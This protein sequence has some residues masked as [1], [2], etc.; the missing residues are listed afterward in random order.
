MP[1]F[2][3]PG[4]LA[5]VGEQIWAVDEFQPVAAVLD[6]QAGRIEQLVSYAAELPAPP[7][8]EEDPWYAGWRVLDTSAGIWVQPFSGGPIAL[9]TTGGLAHAGHSAGTRLQAATEAG[10]WAAPHPPEQDIA[11]LPATPPKLPL[12]PTELCHIRPDGTIMRPRVDRP[13]RELRAGPGGAYVRVDIEPWSRHDLGGSGHWDLAYEQKW[14]LLAPPTAD[15]ETY[16]V[17]EQPAA[18]PPG[19]PAWLG[20]GFLGVG[21]PWHEP[22]DSLNP[23][24]PAGGLRWVLGWDQQQFEHSGE[25]EILATGHHPVSNTEHRRVMLGAGEVLAAAPAKPYLWAAIRRGRPFSPQREQPVELTRID[26]RT[27][28]I[29]TPVPADS[30]EITD[31]RWPRPPKPVEADSYAEYQRRQFDN[32]DT[33]W[34]PVDGGPPKPLATGMRD[35]RSE[36]AGTWPETVVRISFTHEHFPGLRLVRTLPIFDELGRQDPPEYADINLMEDLDTGELPPTSDAADGI[37]QI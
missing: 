15:D 3:R 9:I 20:G 18:S 29:E 23:G 28:H 22:P 25:R 27:N 26:T 19:L 32:L 36:L 8:T 5:P 30:V 11:E 4:F 21:S 16:P 1:R 33:Y 2:L 34:Q 13:V 14:I 31:R 6:S 12:N 37:L 17:E 10:V 7:V 35:C 24:V